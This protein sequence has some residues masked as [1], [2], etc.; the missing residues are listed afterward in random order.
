MRFVMGF[1]ILCFF[2]SI[3]AQTLWDRN[4][5]DSLISLQPGLKNYSIKASCDKIIFLDSIAHTCK[6]DICIGKEALLVIKD[7]ELITK[8]EARRS[9]TKG[10]VSTFYDTPED[11]YLDMVD[12]KKILKCPSSLKGN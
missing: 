12:W 10:Y 4:F 11:F 7:L 8:H 1:V 6:Q 3:K 5:V 2:S 9:E